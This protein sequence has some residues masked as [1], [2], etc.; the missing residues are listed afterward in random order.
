MSGF[1]HEEEKAKDFGGRERDTAG[2]KVT[3]WS[4]PGESDSNHQCWNVECRT[5]EFKKMG[6][7]R[8][9]KI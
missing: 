9:V 3:D 4:E 2:Q 8:F 6:S 5:V 7:G 1:F